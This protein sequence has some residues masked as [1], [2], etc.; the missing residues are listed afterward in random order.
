MLCGTESPLIIFLWLFLQSYGPLDL[1][2]AAAWSVMSR[3]ISNQIL[4]AHKQV[5]IKPIKADSNPKLGSL[6]WD[7]ACYLATDRTIIPIP[8]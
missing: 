3:A 1:G 4:R 7:G 8:N 2:W 5:K 6:I